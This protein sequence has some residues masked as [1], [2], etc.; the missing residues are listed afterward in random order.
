[1]DRR[2]IQPSPVSIKIYRWICNHGQTSRWFFNTFACDMD[3][4]EHAHG[5]VNMVTRAIA[6]PTSL[7]LQYMIYLYLLEKNIRLLS[8]RKCFGC[9]HEIASGHVGFG[10]QGQWKD[11][12]RHH[13]LEAMLEISDD[14][15]TDMLFRCYTCLGVDIPLQYWIFTRPSPETLHSAMTD[16][17]LPDYFWDLFSSVEAMEYE[18]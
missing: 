9:T 13:L 4:R 18:K 11:L 16:C 3:A 1:M 2:R 8:F 6:F 12:I 10:C 17:H 15:I 14:H 7:E 5:D